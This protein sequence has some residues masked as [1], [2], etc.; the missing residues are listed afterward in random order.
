MRK[1]LLTSAS[2]AGLALATLAPAL[3]DKH[4]MADGEVRKIDTAQEKIT[5]RHGPIKTLDM[6]SMTMVFR[7]KDKAMLTSV[8]VGD[9]VKFRAERVNGQITITKMQR[10]K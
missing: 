4:D 8:K 5:L 10:A 2:A 9:K 1:F 7:V 6:E 3:A